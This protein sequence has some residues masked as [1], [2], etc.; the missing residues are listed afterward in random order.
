M[1]TSP[2][3][4]TK[5]TASISRTKAGE[6]K[7]VVSSEVDFRTID[8]STKVGRVFQAPEDRRL[9]QSGFD[10]SASEKWKSQNPQLAIQLA[11]T[12]KRVVDSKR[13]GSKTSVLPKESSS[14]EI[15]GKPLASQNLTT[16]QQFS[17]LSQAKEQPEKRTG[18][19][20][21]TCK[22]PPPESPQ[23]PP[24][25]A[26]PPSTKRISS[27]DNVIFMNSVTTTGERPSQP[28]EQ[29]PLPLGSFPIDTQGQGPPLEQVN[30]GTMSVIPPVT[31]EAFPEV[32]G[33]QIQQAKIVQR[34]PDQSDAAYQPAA[35]EPV[36]TSTDQSHEAT[37]IVA[38]EPTVAGALPQG[39][40]D[41]VPAARGKSGKR[42]RKRKKRCALPSAS[43]SD[44]TEVGSNQTDSTEAQSVPERDSAGR[45]AEP[46]DRLGMTAAAAQLDTIPDAP[47][48]FVDP[49][50]SPPKVT[51][52]YKDDIVYQLKSEYEKPVINTAEAQNETT[53]KQE[54]ATEVPVFEPE[55][56]E[57]ASDT[58]VYASIPLEKAVS[59]PGSKSSER[60]PRESKERAATSKN[61]PPKNRIAESPKV[62][63][64]K[65][66]GSNEKRHKTAHAKDD[67]TECTK[68]GDSKSKKAHKSP[69]QDD[70]PKEPEKLTKQYRSRR[71]SGIKPSKP[72]AETDQKGIE[73]PKETE[74]PSKHYKS[75]RESGIKSSTPSATTDR[76]ET[77]TAKPDKNHNSHL[78]VYKDRPGHRSDTAINVNSHRKKQRNSD[79]DQE[80]AEQRKSRYHTEPRLV[81]SSKSIEH[82]V[83]MVRYPEKYLSKR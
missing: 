42:L 41:T 3:R 76:K 65:A 4:E 83:H 80:T 61:Q 52:S 75:R 74:K 72:S 47:P 28:T 23:S 7:A 2:K 15:D 70:K 20:P 6:P 67:V 54:F 26:D 12:L 64:E 16:S 1:L 36:S 35:E 37:R 71:E 78:K 9:D 56:P 45:N 73:I 55:K 17:P 69:A 32:D 58:A 10:N 38:Q 40:D 53:Q 22:E 19:E 43:I 5:K 33:A 60:E 27:H 44:E 25:T 46:C 14:C 24:S 18:T 8:S 50:V 57:T 49:R 59:E 82:T 77:E 51:R 29:P 21:R 31:V 63:R 34:Q 30:F 81:R 11:Q 39:S 66:S 79:Q 62:T 13:R 68:K 48:I